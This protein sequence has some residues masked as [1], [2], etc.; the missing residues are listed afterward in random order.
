MFRKYSLPQNRRSIFQQIRRYKLEERID[1]GRNGI[2]TA[3]KRADMA[4]GDQLARQWKII[5]T[6]ISSRMGKSAADIAR[7]LNCHPRTVYRD[8]DALQSA[9]FPMYTERVDG[10]SLWSLLDTVK[11]HFPVPLTLTELMAL[12]FNRNVLKVLEGTV[13]YDSLESLFQKVRATLPP[14][15]KKYLEQISKSLVTRPR[16]YKQYDKFKEIIYQVNEAVI[17]R[18]VIDIVYYTMSRRRMTKRK[19]APYQV[20]FYDGSFYLIGQCSL[21]NEVRIFAL[22]RIKM[23][24]ITEETFDIP[25]DFD[26]DALMNKSFGVFKGPS[27]KI[28][29]WFD[30]E[31]AGYIREKVWHSSQRIQEQKDGSI[32]FKAEVSGSDEVK[33]WVMS[34][35]AKALVLEPE[36]LRKEIQSEC[37]L[38]LA[39]YNNHVEVDLATG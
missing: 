7:E 4:R 9:G 18:K 32:I 17:Q 19:V 31:I 21:A 1:F 23:L 26:F 38:T 33:F 8:L 35:G 24:H 11:H 20:W 27:V 16:P 5:Q 39:Q 6:L 29:V 2:S 30:K 12:H 10:K 14:E 37:S 22:D 3:K 36:S 13:F 34:W 15:S 25:S 28:K